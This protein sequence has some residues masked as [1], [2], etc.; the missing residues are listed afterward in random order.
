MSGEGH[1]FR[2][3]LPFRVARV[4]AN[5]GSHVVSMSCAWRGCSVWFAW[6]WWGWCRWC[7]WCTK[8]GETLLD[9]RSLARTA[10]DDLKRLL[11][12]ARV[13]YVLRAMGIYTIDCYNSRSFCI[14]FRP[15]ARTPWTYAH[16]VMYDVDAYHRLTLL[17]SVAQNFT[18]FRAYRCIS[19][20]T[21][22]VNDH[23]MANTVIEP[24]WTR[25][26]PHTGNRKCFASVYV[27]IYMYVKNNSDVQCPW[28]VSVSTYMYW[29]CINNK[30]RYE[31]LPT[32]TCLL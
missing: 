11:F 31:Y 7:R 17:P 23:H 30:C 4:S 8:R 3:G 18:P 12:R 28:T 13:N 22:S 24:L 21:W 10:R 27:S 2:G 9:D 25:T 29:I 16:A 6:C 1:R 15:A 5:D 20:H 26:R 19:S 32:K 14:V